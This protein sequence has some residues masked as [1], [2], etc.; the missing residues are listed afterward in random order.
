MDVVA[1]LL[2]LIVLAAVVWLVSGPL[3]AGTH[4]QE[5]YAGRRADLEAARDSK[6]REIRDAEMDFRTGKLSDEDFRR[7]DRALR[8]EAVKILRDLDDIRP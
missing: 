4:E 6:Y 8:A 2:I 3:R 5:H 1:P 7:L